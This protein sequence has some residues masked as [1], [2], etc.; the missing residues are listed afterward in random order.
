MKNWVHFKTF[1][2]S[3]LESQLIDLLKNSERAKDLG[4]KLTRGEWWL[5]ICSF[6][7][8]QISWGQGKILL[9]VL[10]GLEFL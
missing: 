1:W 4:A 5:E 6:Y 10:I 7:H 2:K 3:D 8:H 9:A